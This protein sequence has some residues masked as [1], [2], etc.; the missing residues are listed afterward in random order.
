MVTGDAAGMFA[1][2]PG[3]VLTAPDGARSAATH[4]TDWLATHYT[5]WLAGR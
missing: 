3:D 1:A 2:A 5:D 4:Y